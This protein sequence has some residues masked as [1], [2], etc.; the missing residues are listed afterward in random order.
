[1]ISTALGG[2]YEEFFDGD[3]K[4]YLDIYSYVYKKIW[5]LIYLTKLYVMY[6]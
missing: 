5:F 4:T 6:I 2:E 3:A 1:M